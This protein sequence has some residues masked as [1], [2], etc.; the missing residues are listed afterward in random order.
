MLGAVDRTRLG[1]LGALAAAQAKAVGQQDAAASAA[2]LKA[3]LTEGPAAGLGRQHRFTRVASGWLPSSLV[4]G[5]AHDHATLSKDGCDDEGFNRVSEF[6]GEEVLKDL[7]P[8]CPS[9]P[10][11]DGVS[12]GN[13]DHAATR[14]AGPQMTAAAHSAGC[15]RPASLQEEAEQEVDWEEESITFCKVFFEAMARISAVTSPLLYDEI[16]SKIWAEI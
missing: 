11:G 8:A 6:D 2:A 5:A 15:L 4:A 1:Q 10:A 14:A 3:W 12:N 7:M 16:A 13:E 9:S